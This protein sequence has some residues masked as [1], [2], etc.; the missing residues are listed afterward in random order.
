MKT[1]IGE[2]IGRIW[3]LFMALIAFYI[4]KIRNRVKVRGRKNLPKENGILFVSNH[5][6]LIDSLLIG[7]SVS[8]IF[9]IFFHYNRVPFNAPDYDNFFKH[10]IGK[11]LIYLSKCIPAH[12]HTRKMEIIMK[13]V[14]NFCQALKKS[15][16]VLFFEGTRTRTGEI[17]DC[18]FGVAHTVMQ[19]RPKYVI[20]IYLH[21]VQPIMPIES[22]FNFT[23]IYGGHK[24]EI[25]IGKPII[26][27]DLL[28]EE[29][30]KQEIREAII[31]LQESARAKA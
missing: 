20:P 5:Q 30:V 19:V 22:G 8:S 4:F 11:Q 2:S 7:I 9:D 14:A 25:Y 6:T 12:R 1:I 28:N 3:L 31:K 23:K 21:D 24:G 18:K 27:S 29:L 10:P 26:F 13:D 15:N 17:G 16:L